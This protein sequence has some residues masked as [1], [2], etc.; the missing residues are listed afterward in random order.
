VSQAAYTTYPTFGAWRDRCKRRRRQ[1]WNCDRCQIL[2]YRRYFPEGDYA[3]GRRNRHSNPRNG[4]LLGLINIWG[5]GDC[6]MDDFC[7]DTPV[8][9]D[10]NIGCPT[11]VDSCTDSP[12]MDMVQNYMDTTNDECQNVFTQDQKTRILTVLQTRQ[13]YTGCF[14]RMSNGYNLW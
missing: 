5:D 12:G 4:P 14:R 8:A 6:S 10:G 3:D 2:W 1:R 13:G 9:A 11:D 7:A